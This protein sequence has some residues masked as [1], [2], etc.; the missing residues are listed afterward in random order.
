MYKSIWA[1]QCINGQINGMLTKPPRHREHPPN[2]ESAI[3]QLTST[4]VQ[5]FSSHIHCV[6]H[7]TA[8]A[9]VS[10]HVQA[11]VGLLEATSIAARAVINTLGGRAPPEGQ[12]FAMAVRC[13]PDYPQPLEEGG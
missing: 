6:L 5:V 11:Q 1:Y 9:A 3:P 12:G 2:A 10:C 8:S 4:I 13:P 7:K